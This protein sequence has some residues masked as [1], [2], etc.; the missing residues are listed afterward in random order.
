MTTKKVLI[1][2]GLGNGS[3]IA[4]AIL[5]AN[6]LGY[7]EWTC[8]GFLNDDTPI[9]EKIDIFPVV[10]T[11]RQVGE[12]LDKGYYFI[13]TILR[14]DGQ[15]ERLNLFES[16]NIPDDR[17]ATFVHPSAYIAPN[18]KLGPGTVIMPH[19]A[20]SSG[21]RF[22][23]GCL[24]M[25]SV[26]IGHD[27]EIGDFCHIAAQ[28]CVGAYLKVGIGV[29]IGLN[30]TIREHLSIGN[31]ATIGMGAVLTKD[32]GEKEIWVGNPARFLRLAK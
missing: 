3:V 12:F 6:N 8:E 22:G 32:V 20:V 26:T 19:V 25:V 28:S 1:I 24:V 16:L 21:T 10:G 7:N 5:H 2:G 31:Y 18:V 29:H 30:S 4:N 9:G 15:F 27:N 13:D 23:K 14:I 17:L 11:L